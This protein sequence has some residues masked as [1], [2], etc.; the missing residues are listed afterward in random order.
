MLS[1][2]RCG[3]WCDRDRRDL[4]QQLCNWGLTVRWTASWICR[5]VCVFNPHRINKYILNRTVWYFRV[6]SRFGVARQSRSGVTVLQRPLFQRGTNRH[7]IS[8]PL[9]WSTLNK[10]SIYCNIL[11]ADSAASASTRQ[12]HCLHACSWC[13]ISIVA[14]AYRRTMM[15]TAL[16]CQACLPLTMNCG[17]FSPTEL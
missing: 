11:C 3:R 10:K 7:C 8:F 9:S 5:R 15:M 1:G 2:R 6:S 12:D 16:A 4:S 17:F 13:I 14:E